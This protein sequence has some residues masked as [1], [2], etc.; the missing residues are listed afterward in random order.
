M[1]SQAVCLLSQAIMKEE[2]FLEISPVNVGLKPLDQTQ[3]G[4]G[5]NNLDI[6]SVV[7]SVTPPIYIYNQPVP[8]S[9]TP[10]AIIPAVPIQNGDRN[11]SDLATILQFV[12]LIYIAAIQKNNATSVNIISKFTSALVKR[13]SHALTDVAN[14]I[15]SLSL[16]EIS[17]FFTISHSHILSN[18]QSHSVSSLS[19]QAC[20]KE[21]LTST[22]NTN[23][24]VIF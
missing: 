2:A 7:P 21:P 6:H 4:K 9:S 24:K 23:I 13:F 19:I 17:P 5:N 1:N 11:Q 22:H 20:V 10:S 18:I 8:T 15:S 14:Y 16:T 3:R 12:G